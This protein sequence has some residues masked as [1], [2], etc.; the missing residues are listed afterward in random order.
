MHVRRTFQLLAA[1]TFGAA[2]VASVSTLGAVATAQQVRSTPERL[3]QMEHHFREVGLIHEAVIRGDLQAV[4]QPAK[5]LAEAEAPRGLVAPTEPQVAAMRLAA[6]RAADAP[7]LAS[8]AAATASML[9]S[10]GECHRAAGT[11][12]AAPTPK[13]PEIAGAVGHMIEHQRAAD[14]ML[15]GLFVPSQ[16]QWN[17]GVTRIAGA[18]LESQS[19]P[20]DK[21]LTPEIRKAEERVHQLGERARQATEWKDRGDVY[22]QMLTTCAR[23]HSLHGVVWGPRRAPSGEAN[24]R[25]APGLVLIAARPSARGRS[26]VDRTVFRPRC[27]RLP[28]LVPGTNGDIWRTR[29]GQREEARR[30]FHRPRSSRTRRHDPPSGSTRT[31]ARSNGSPRSVA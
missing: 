7:D 1:A 4:R 27:C 20:R 2:I 22:A 31:R 25:A 5:R 9:L 24:V 30:S 12:P 18:P 8:A 10:C 21:K 17:S 28:S 15:E 16:S 14:E 26:P 3:A 29:L 13:R 23:C 6:K 11:M 19:L